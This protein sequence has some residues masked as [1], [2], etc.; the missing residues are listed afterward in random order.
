MILPTLAHLTD[1]TPWTVSAENCALVRL[2]ASR[3]ERSRC[4]GLFRRAVRT[5]F[6]GSTVMAAATKAMFK[7]ALS[8]PSSLYLYLTKSDDKNQLNTILKDS[9]YRSGPNIIS[10]DLYVEEGIK[11][12]FRDIIWTGNFIYEDNI[13]ERVLGVEKG[14]VYNM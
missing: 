6:S 9:I 3:T 4:M 12:Y 11:Y 7:R 10:I 1:T 14:D 5:W 2:F 8:I 13:L